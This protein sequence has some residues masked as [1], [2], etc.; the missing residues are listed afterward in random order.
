MAEV[1]CYTGLIKV[2]HIKMLDRIRFLPIVVSVLLIHLNND[3]GLDSVSSGVSLALALIGFAFV[4][5]SFVYFKHSLS[6]RLLY[7]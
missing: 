7:C 2:K 6:V 4:I 5:F 1:I 3:K